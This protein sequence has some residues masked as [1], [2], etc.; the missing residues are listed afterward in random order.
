MKTQYEEIVYKKFKVYNHI[1]SYDFLLIHAI[2]SSIQI[3]LI[4][5][6]IRTYPCWQ[7]F[8][9]K[10]WSY[11]IE[12]INKELGFFDLVVFFGQYIKI[13]L[14]KSIIKLKIP[15]ENKYKYYVQTNLEKNNTI[16]YLMEEYPTPEIEFYVN[17]S[18]FAIERNN[19]LNCDFIPLEDISPP[20]IHKIW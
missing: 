20:E 9:G 7:N 15:L 1:E 6:L 12:N 8:D 19:L 2:N 10:K 3:N 13:D 18:R 16:L 4:K 11:V 5:F 14:L 17:N